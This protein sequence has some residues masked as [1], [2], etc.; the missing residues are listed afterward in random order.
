MRPDRKA[1][2]EAVGKIKTREDL[3]N[4]LDLLNLTDEEREIAWMILANGWSRTKIAMEI[5]YSEHQVK[6]KVAKIYDKLI[7]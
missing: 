6:R 2:R 4:Y 1:A 5:G 3:R 7:Y